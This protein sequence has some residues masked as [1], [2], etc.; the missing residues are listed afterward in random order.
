MK[1]EDK[2]ELLAFQIQRTAGAWVG[3]I[4]AGTLR[5]AAMTLHR[6]DEACCG[7]G[8]DYAS[9][10]T[11]RDEDTGIPYRCTYPHYG[12]ST[13]VRI[14]DLEKGA[15]ARVAEIC[16]RHGLHWYRQTD[17]RGCAL[18]IGKAP[19]TESNL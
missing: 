10:S 19:L 8:N 7:T 17:P 13:R 15:E 3:L 4:D 6:W 12:K 2:N 11:E 16:A 1:T 5:R 9:W 14:P 18:Y